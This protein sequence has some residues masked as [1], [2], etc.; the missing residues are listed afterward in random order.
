M[1]GFFMISVLGLYF[2]KLVEFMF[3]ECDCFGYGLNVFVI[4]DKQ[5][6]M[7]NIMGCCVDGVIIYEEL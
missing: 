7:S 2:Y 5:V 6:I 1:L 4:K 3:C